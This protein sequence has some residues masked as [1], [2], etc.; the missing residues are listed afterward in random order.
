MI[1]YTETAGHH[2]NSKGIKSLR[3]ILARG[4]YLGRCLGSRFTI[5]QSV[6]A[7]SENSADV[8]M[9]AVELI[10][11]RVA[12]EALLTL[13]RHLENKLSTVS[14]LIKS[15]PCQHRIISM[16]IDSN[17]EKF[18]CRLCTMAGTS[19][20]WVIGSHQYWIQ[21]HNTADFIDTN[22]FLPLL[23]IGGASREWSIQMEGQV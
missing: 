6:F 1:K 11:I 22:A 3:H 8:Q 19:L 16:L 5:S 13:V 20:V 4:E 12:E 15:K 9:A 17:T 14:P 23:I 21:A 7:E 18:S 2:P 10:Y